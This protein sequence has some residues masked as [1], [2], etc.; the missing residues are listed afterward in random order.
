ME[1]GDGTVVVMPTHLADN[2][3]HFARYL[4]A[5]GVE[6]VPG[7]GSDLL[8]AAHAVGLENRDD[9]YHAFRAVTISRPEDIPI[10]DDAFNL[11]FGHGWRRPKPTLV[12]PPERMSIQI[13]V[14]GNDH[15]FDDQDMGEGTDQ[16][17]ASRAERLAHR[18]FSELTA[19]EIAE[20]RRL[21]ARMM[22]HPADALSRRWIA[23]RRGARPDMRRTLRNA[24]GAGSEMMPLEFSARKPRRRPLVL[25]ADVSGS[26]EKYVEMILYFAHAAPS[27]MGRVESFVFSTRLTRIT[28]ELRRRDVGAALRLVSDAVHDW[29]GGTR[30]GES[31]E[32]F[33][34][35]WSRRVCRGGPIGVIVSDGWDRGDAAVLDREMSMFARTMHRVIW[36]NP[37]AG[38]DGYAPETRGMRT[39][40]PH[41]DDFL[42]VATLADLTDVIRLLESVPARK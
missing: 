3:V 24:V 31:L 33:N 9:A 42:P 15:D 5:R 16:L 7:T 39:V 36:L 38:R 14:L 10:F 6:T 20:V 41:V 17:G 11:F 1:R 29:S 25:L 18:D 34:R 2:L 12:E 37:L 32:T 35:Q 30:I 27:R 4:R 23:D 22:W 28:H 19:D 40:L 13:P 8:Q 21:I 26:M